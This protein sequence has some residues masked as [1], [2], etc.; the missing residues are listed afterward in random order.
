MDFIAHLLWSAI[1]FTGSQLYAAIFLGVM[2]DLIPFGLHLLISPFRNK[3]QVNHRDVNSMMSYYDLPQNRWVRNLYDWTHSLVMWALFFGVFVLIGHFMGFFP[4]FM[5]AWL[6]HIVVDIP[7]HT[8]A[9]FAPRFLTPL[10]R[11]NFDGWSWAH[12]KFMI[13]NYSLIILFGI[14]RLLG[15]LWII[16]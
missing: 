2:P 8:R 10:S 15:L 3:T 1:I 12:P 13:V 9:F 7:T 4:W 14:L 11:Y 16:E 6:L 5:F